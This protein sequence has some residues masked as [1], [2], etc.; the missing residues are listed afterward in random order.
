L[1]APKRSREI[2]ASRMYFRAT[3]SN[4]SRTSIYDK[5]DA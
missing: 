1:A 2:L 4:T 5:I 3:A